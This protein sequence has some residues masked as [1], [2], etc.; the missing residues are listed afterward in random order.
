MVY[1]EFEQ[2]VQFFF[3]HKCTVSDFEKLLIHETPKFKT[4]LDFYLSNGEK[5]VLIS[6]KSANFLNLVQF[7]NLKIKNGG[8]RISYYVY[9][10]R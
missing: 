9:S 3:D 4:G 8:S 2:P 7:E 1:T 5:D 6:D 10:E